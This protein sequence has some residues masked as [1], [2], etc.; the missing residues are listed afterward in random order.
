MKGQ[1]ADLPWQKQGYE[2]KMT[3][4][5]SCMLY[6]TLEQTRFSLGLNFPIYKMEATVLHP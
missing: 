4:E 3:W 5:A 1:G 2:Y 6:R